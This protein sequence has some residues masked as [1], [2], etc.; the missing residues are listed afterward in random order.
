MGNHGEACFLQA[1]EA[2]QRVD[3]WARQVVGKS[4]GTTVR[5]EWHLLEDEDIEG[6]IAKR[7]AP[8]PFTTLCWYVHLE[9]WIG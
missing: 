6:T 7:Y 1:S 3:S 2:F 4:F 5:V 8:R 9:T